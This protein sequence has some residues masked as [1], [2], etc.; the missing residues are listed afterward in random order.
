MIQYTPVV[1][2]GGSGTRLWPLSRAGFPKQ[3][4]SFGHAHSLYQQTL[5]RLMDLQ[6]A[7]LQ[8]QQSLIVTHEE[9]R[10]MAL[11]QLRELQMDHAV[12]SPTLILEP[13][14]RNTAA[15]LTL[16]ALQATEGGQ[17]SILVAS[18]SDAFIGD[19]AAYLRAVRHGI[20]HAATAGVVILGVPATRAETG[21][22]YIRFDATSAESVQPVLKF[23]EKPTA[24]VAQS[25]VDAGDYAWNSG[26]F[27][28]RASLWLK[29]LGAFRADILQACHAAWHERSLD[30]PVASNAQFV[31]PH[32]QLFAQVPSQSVDYAVLE[33]CPE[34]NYPIDMIPIS[35]QWSD[36]GAW[37]AVW[38]SREADSQGNVA[39]G[40]VLLEQSHNNYIS[41]NSRLVC[42]VG[43]RDMV[44]VETPDAVLVSDKA[45]SQQVKAIV[46]QLALSK[47]SEHELHRKVHRPWGWYDSVDEGSRHKVKRIHVKPGASL[48][49]QKHAKR[50]EHWIV[51]KGVAQ[52]VCGQQ[53][54]T[55]QENESTYIPLGEVHRLSNPGTTD[56]EIIEVQSGSYLG[57]DDIVRLEDTYG[58]TTT[59]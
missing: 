53:T 2:C 23:V 30:T 40:D 45:R 15:A 55:L 57:E 41:A 27:I 24:Q 39:Q 52:V 36:L 25:Y 38:A 13:S 7:Q 47:R 12:A 14:A 32:A 34:S 37:D 59:K 26:M 48:S 31:R 17:D 56:L 51:V 42:A 43:V 8:A 49:L 10:F 21:Y 6:D 50:A 22:G 3:F 5:V 28:L 18:P 44:I 29:A 16:A 46:E 58:R 9:Q 20:A 1:L 19:H 11:E 33:K 4:L 54:L 35:A